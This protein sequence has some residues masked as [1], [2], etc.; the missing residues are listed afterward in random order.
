M[1]NK[2]T[3][4]AI[5]AMNNRSEIS[6][7]DFPVALGRFDRVHAMGLDMAMVMFYDVLGM[8]AEVSPNKTMMVIKVDRNFL[9]AFSIEEFVTQ[10]N[11]L[12][13]Q[14][15]SSKFCDVAMSLI[16]DRSPYI[17]RYHNYADYTAYQEKSRQDRRNNLR[18]L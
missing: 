18:S 2:E 13:R 16:D 12:H 4:E 14:G 3:I 5:E 17:L 15:K 6:F 8:N 10:E 9:T 1:S 11:E 7:D